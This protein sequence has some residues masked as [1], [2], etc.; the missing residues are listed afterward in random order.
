[1]TRTT[2]LIRSR[3]RVD[4]LVMG[5][6]LTLTGT[7]LVVAILS[8]ASV[9]AVVALLGAA[10]VLLLFA[11]ALRQRSGGRLSAA[12]LE[13]AVA[14]TIHTMDELRKRTDRLESLLQ[15]T[16]AIAHS[17]D[18]VPAWIALSDRVPLGVEA[19]DRRVDPRVL[20][21]LTERVSALDAQPLVVVLADDA[22]GPAAARVALATRADA[23]VVILTSLPET[24]S[25]FR[26]TVGD[27][28]RV[29][30]RSGEPVVRSFGRIAGPWFSP[31]SL[32]G[33]E[34]VRLVVVAGP[35][36][37]FGANARHAVIAGL[38]T[39]TEHAIVLVN[40]SDESA[41]RRAVGLW[42]STAPDGVV[43][44]Q[45][46]PWEVELELGSAAER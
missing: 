28:P 29:E 3:L 11:I 25:A 35:S 10:V 23:R 4:L 8:P 17:A 37:T 1:V 33:L 46:S 27:E 15:R 36:L 32:L 38:S 19:L 14:D 5:V 16:K 30:I 6:A 2:R 20:L 39:L 12:A 44:A 9:A 43:V 40:E 18:V 26:H 34:G 22:I 31:A 24:A 45:R 42:Q 21:A 13:S 41:V 7:G